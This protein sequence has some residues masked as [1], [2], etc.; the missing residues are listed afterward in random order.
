[1]RLTYQEEDM[2]IKEI[3]P[4]LGGLAIFL[5]FLLGYMLFGTHSSTMNAVLIGGFII[6]LTGIIDDIGEL[7]AKHQFIGQLGAALVITLYG[8]LLIKDI[9]AFGLYINLSWMSYP[10]TIFFILGCINCINFIDGLDGLSGGIS[11]I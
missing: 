11:S 10:I 7:D 9:D 5:G 8:G 4:K 3:T 2:L 6:I 1:M